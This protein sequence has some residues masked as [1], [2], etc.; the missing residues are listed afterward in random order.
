[1]NSKSE[2]IFKGGRAYPLGRVPTESEISDDF[3][4]IANSFRAHRSERKTEFDLV[5]YPELKKL[6]ASRNKIESFVD[7]AC[8]TGS[9]IIRLRKDGLLNGSKIIGVDI[10]RVM[11]RLA[12]SEKL[13]KNISFNIGSITNLSMIKT[14]TV[15][16]A[17]CIYGLDYTETDVALREIN[18]ILKL[19]ARLIVLLPHEERNQEYWLNG[20][21]EGKYVEGPMIEIWPDSIREILKKYYFYLNTWDKCFEKAGFSIIKKIEPTVT[22]EQLENAPELKRKYSFTKHRIVIYLLKKVDNK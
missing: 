20:G 22:E 18:R 17:T 1:M 6:V 14:E 2:N 11:I 5:A 4:K 10:S 8:G 13:S 9:L 7:L 16:L 19:G 21:N 12:N 3:D 15:D